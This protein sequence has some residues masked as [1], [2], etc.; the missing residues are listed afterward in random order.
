MSEQIKVEFHQHDNFVYGRCVEMPEIIRGVG[1]IIE[2]NGITIS[3]VRFPALYSD[4][5]C[6]RGTNVT[7]DNEWFSWGFSSKEKAKMI[8]ENFQ[9][10]INQWNEQ[11][12]PI[13]LGINE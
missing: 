3:S 10:L 5:L 7:K 13:E 12:A 1:T 11:N 4:A 9:A 6:L 2:T 8:I